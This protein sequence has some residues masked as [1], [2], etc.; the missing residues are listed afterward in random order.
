MSVM[1]ILMALAAPAYG[2]LIGSTRS[3]SANSELAA[4]LNRARFEAASRR[5]HVVACPSEDQSHCDH[6]TQWHHGWI[7]FEDTDHNRE[8]SSSEPVISISQAQ[9]PGVAMLSSA[10]RMRVDYQP[11]GSAGGTNLTLTTC[12]RAADASAA[13]SLFINN[14][15]RIRSAPAAPD[16]SAACLHVAQ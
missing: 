11:D 15:G 4:S 7:V 16:A 10:G 2:R 14:A 1:G 6:T 3:G 5:A 8:H 12:D 9:Y 13:T